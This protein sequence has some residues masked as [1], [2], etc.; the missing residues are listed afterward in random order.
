MGPTSEADRHDDT[1]SGHDPGKPDIIAAAASAQDGGLAIETH[2]PLVNTVRERRTRRGWSQQELADRSSIS[3]AGISAIE[4][5][6]LVPSTAAALAL[7]AALE[8]RVEDLFRL[9]GPDPAGVIPWAW[10][11]VRWPCRYWLAEVNCSI[12]AYPVEA[13]WTG[14]P[15]H[16]GRAQDPLVRNVDTA[17]A[18]RTLVVASCDPAAGLL[19]A[20]YARETGFRMIV[21][22]RS[23]TRALELLAQ[24]LVHVAGTHLATAGHLDAN[25]EATRICLPA[26]ARLLRLA[27][28]E[29][30]L[31]TAPHIAADSVDRVLS[32]ELDWV[33]REPGSAARECLE[34]L[35]PGGPPPARIAYD[36]RGVAEAIRC[37]WAEV[38]VCLRLASEEAGLG[39][40]PLRFELADLAFRADAEHDP[41][42]AAL[43]RLV[44]SRRF[45]SWL[46][47]LPGYD[48][49]ASGQIETVAPVAT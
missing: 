6:R 8:C 17:S 47:E 45:R 42:I 41:R 5:G 48:T 35:C 3:R 28:W 49:S 7:A 23:S 11:P 27:R 46:G 15:P 37:G 39:F 34:Q 26:H 25:A 36:H 30:G 29:E 10:S 12:R 24:G 22:P 13:A 16:D 21:L 33:G 20:A 40:L 1:G 2:E 14:L 4:T 18:S 19:A 31:A 44:Q 9:A 43:V 32:T 38:G